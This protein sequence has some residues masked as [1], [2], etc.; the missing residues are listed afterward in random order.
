VLLITNNPPNAMSESSIY[1]NNPSE[2]IISYIQTLDDDRISSEFS[3][4]DDVEHISFENSNFQQISGNLLAGFSNLERV[5]AYWCGLQTIDVNTFGGAESDNFP[6][7]L[8]VA[9]LQAN[10]ITDIGAKA[11]V[12]LSHLRTLYLG[13]NR[14]TTI[15]DDAFYGLAE[16]EVLNLFQN[17]IVTFDVNIFAGL[18]SLYEIHLDK[19]ELTTFN[20]D[21]FQY[22]KQLFQVHLSEHFF[23]NT[24][25]YVAS[26]CLGSFTNIKLSEKRF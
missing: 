6:P 22:N 23:K 16:L 19:N 20:L 21:I 9:D 5:T 18:R 4:Y 26:A 10:E 25:F 2:C 8:K 3:N 24:N 17:S 15:D 7:N 12:R 13:Y 11:F 1:C 14:I